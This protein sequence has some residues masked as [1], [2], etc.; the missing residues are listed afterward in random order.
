MAGERQ[1]G[2]HG[3]GGDHFTGRHQIRAFTADDDDTVLLEYLGHDKSALPAG[4][5]A[6]ATGVVQDEMEVG[7]SLHGSQEALFAKAGAGAFFATGRDDQES[8]RA[9]DR[10]GGEEKIGGGAAGL[11]KV[12]VLGVTNPTNGNIILMGD[13]NFV[14]G[15]GKG[16]QPL[17]SLLRL[18][19]L[20]TQEAPVII[21]NDV[22]DKAQ[23]GTAGG[24][25]DGLMERVACDAAQAGTGMVDEGRCMRAG[26]G[27]FSGRADG[28]CFAPTGVTGILM[29]LDDTGGDDEVRFD[30]GAMQ[31]D[32]HATGGVAQ[33]HLDRRILGLIVDHV[34]TLDDAGSQPGYFFFQG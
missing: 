33:V 23:A 22:N 10:G 19:S 28:D 17:K 29:R 27:L 5:I 32:R 20:H 4:W 12:G 13:G 1:G 18:A 21:Q 16:D 8:T 25:E 3:G 31:L 14:D 9:H 2:L 34:V 26:D 11:V 7:R 6:I 30:H 24:L 15:P